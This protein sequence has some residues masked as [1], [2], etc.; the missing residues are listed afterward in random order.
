[1]RSRLL[2]AGLV[3]V[4]TGAIAC[5]GG[6]DGGSRSDEVMARPNVLVIY[7]DDQREGLE[8]M[9]KT[10]RW[11]GSG[12]RDFINA[13]TTVPVC[14]PSRA[15]LFTGQYTHNHGVTTNSGVDKLDV[16]TTLQRYLQDAGYRTAMFGKY[17]NG[18]EEAPPHFDYWGTRVG[19]DR[20]SGA[21]W[22]V[23]GE[24]TPIDQYSTD[25]VADSSVEFLEQSDKD[26]DSQPWFLYVAP[27]A[28][29]APSEA[30][31]KYARAD[32]PE[33]DPDRSV[34]QTDPK[35]HYTTKLVRELI[36]FE[37]GKAIRKKM[38]RALMSVDDLVGDVSSALSELDEENTIAI[39]MSDNG[40][41]WGEHGLSEKTQPYTESIAVPLL[42]RWPG[43]IEAGT[44]DDRLVG[45]ID[46]A[47][48][49]LDATGVAP[50]VAAAMD[51]H[52]VLDEE[53]SRSRLL[54]EHEDDP[55]SARTPTWAS[56]RTG[57]YQY[58]EYYGKNGRSIVFREYYDLVDDPRQMTN[59]F[60]DGVGDND[61]DVRALS[62]RL[63]ADRKCSGTR[64]P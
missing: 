24:P 36:G 57:T 52:S 47:P 20:Y 25:Y 4:G 6:R 62:K 48:T 41:M 35:G 44:T 23:Q 28:P 43:S 14:C 60:T 17:M 15:G 2:V 13:Y 21:E 9:P 7:T 34:F 8:V 27:D 53:W 19:R 55:K 49:I 58:I 39:F 33:W 12:G 22:N 37:E 16:D 30:A 11:F 46:L 61:P 26:Q 5:T 42:M 51:G 29:H 32:V 18:W 31:P 45:N 64:C 63:A 3:L 40:Y 1:M 10:R 54:V 56:S 59:L 38:Y 50:E